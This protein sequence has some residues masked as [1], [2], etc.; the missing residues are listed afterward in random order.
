[1][2]SHQNSISFIAVLAREG[3]VDSKTDA[4]AH[5]CEQDEEIKWFPFHQSYA[6]FPGTKS[7]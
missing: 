3:S 4:V 6:M 5:D 2:Y 7:I 1:M